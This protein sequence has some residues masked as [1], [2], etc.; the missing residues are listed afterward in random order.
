VSDGDPAGA[1]VAVITAVRF[2]FR[3][4]RDFGSVPSLLKAATPS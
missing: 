1:V 4:I 2:I 3:S